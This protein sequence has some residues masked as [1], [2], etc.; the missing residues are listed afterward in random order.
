MKCK[1]ITCPLKDLQDEINKWLENGT[2]EIIETNQSQLDYTITLTI[3][4]LDQ[5]ELR[6]KKLKKIDNINKN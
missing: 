4:Y 5:K 2:Y 1:V 6:S 3:F